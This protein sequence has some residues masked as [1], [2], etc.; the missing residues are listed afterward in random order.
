[1][2][3]IEEPSLIYTAKINQSLTT[4]AAI[5]TLLT[6]YADSHVQD[7]NRKDDKSGQHDRIA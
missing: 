3:K 6:S 4:V 2:E 1:M 7:P 5:R